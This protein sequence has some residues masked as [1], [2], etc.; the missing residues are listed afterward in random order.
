MNNRGP[1]SQKTI[2][3]VYR[4]IKELNYH[5]NIVACQLYKK[6]TNIIGILFPTVANPFF[7]ELT[8]GLEKRLYNE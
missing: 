3:N 6:Q 8:E 2:D 4:A 1:L 7:G 5:P